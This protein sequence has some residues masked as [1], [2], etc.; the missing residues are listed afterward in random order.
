[1]PSEEQG[2]ARCGEEVGAA[3]THCVALGGSRAFPDPQL[4]GRQTALRPL[5]ACCPLTVSPHAAT[6]QTL[7]ADGSI[8]NPPLLGR[9]QIFVFSFAC[10]LCSFSRVVV[11]ERKGL[12][13][14]TS[15]S[16]LSELKAINSPPM[17]L[18]VCEDHGECF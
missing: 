8:Y 16:A 9:P 4:L 11:L 14:L 6:R 1:M 2:L 12:L 3:Q 13:C 17:K 5:L 18:Y 10:C 7:P 15:L